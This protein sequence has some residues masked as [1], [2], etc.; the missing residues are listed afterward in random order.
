MNCYIMILNE[1]I[2]P[3]SCLVLYCLLS[4]FHFCFLFLFSFFVPSD[5]KLLWKTCPNKNKIFI[6]LHMEELPK[7]EF[8]LADKRF[9]TLI[10]VWFWRLITSE[11]LWH[12]EMFN[13]K[14]LIWISENCEI[15]HT[16][17]WQCTSYIN[18]RR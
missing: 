8:T 15:I 14:Q 11:F 10:N 1:N 18:K 13:I 9:Y 2:V 17:T 5:I 12:F 4:V 7:Q 6:G 3:Q 16:H